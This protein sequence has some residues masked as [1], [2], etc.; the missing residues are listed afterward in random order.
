MARVDPDSVGLHPGWR[1]ALAIA[2]TISPWGEGDSGEIVRQA[3]ERDA[4]F[5]R[6]LEPI[7]PD[8][9]TYM[10][11]VSVKANYGLSET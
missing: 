9:A 8:S 6:L 4:Q 11:E 10:N 5:V 2:I 7:S 3:R 1:K